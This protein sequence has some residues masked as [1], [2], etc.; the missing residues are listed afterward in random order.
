MDGVLTSVNPPLATPLIGTTKRLAWPL[1]QNNTDL[2]SV[3]L[4]QSEKSLMAELFWPVATID[5]CS[6]GQ[7]CCR[8]L[9]I[10]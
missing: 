4:I 7:K 5:C 9:Y 1:E 2:L 10:L 6:R 3:W 8:F